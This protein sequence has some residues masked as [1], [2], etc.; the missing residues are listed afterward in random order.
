M[1]QDFIA[2]KYVT[3]SS[4]DSVSKALGSMQKDKFVIVMKGNS[5]YGIVSKKSLLRIGVSMPDEKVSTISTKG[6]NV[7]K[8]LNDEEIAQLFVQSGLPALVVFDKAKILGVISRTEFLQR[9]VAPEIGSEKI[10][11]V[12]TK[13]VITIK[14][15]DTL[16]KALAIFKE[17]NISKLVV[18]DNGVKGVISLTNVL[19]YFLR[20]SKL[21]ISNLKSTQVK[22]VMK[23]EVYG[24]TS[25]D[26]IRKAI[27][28][29]SRNHTSSLVVFGN[30]LFNKKNSM[31]GIVTKT[32]ILTRYLADFKKTKVKISIASKID[33]VDNTLIIEKLEALGKILDKGTEVFVYVKKGKER[34]RGM[35]LINVRLRVT[36]PG[37]SENISVEGWGL[38]HATEL[39]IA[40]LKRRLVEVDFS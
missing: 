6:P 17:H 29:F 40:K 36:M 34:F 38:E 18:M 10:E 35:P 20:S 33:D 37:I 1:W 21:T 30:K 3:I 26:T 15:T 39:A 32:D 11:G 14:P 24:I 9:V 16:A 25:T 13:D 8:N 28:S 12:V 5:Y 4:E 31:F 19:N 2:S 7:T 27:D 23:E 22:D